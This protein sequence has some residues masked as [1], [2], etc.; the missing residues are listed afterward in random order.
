MH[1]VLG[2]PNTYQKN[3]QL[4]KL[5]NLITKHSFNN[6]L[7]SGT[8]GMGKT[9]LAN[10]I[11]SNSHG[12]LVPLSHYNDSAYQDEFGEIEQA[13]ILKKYHNIVGTVHCPNVNPNINLAI[14]NIKSVANIDSLKDLNLNLLIFLS[15][16]YQSSGR[17]ME[18]KFIT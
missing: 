6:I 18:F 13:N 11:C 5:I 10:F 14:K 16:D 1:I 2:N 3:D 12:G 8:S 7:I 15:L 17:I 4:L 9:T